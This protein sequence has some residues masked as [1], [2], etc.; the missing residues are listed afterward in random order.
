MNVVEAIRDRNLLGA[1]LSPIATWSA[2]LTVLKAANGV[3]LDEGEAEFFAGVSGGRS[4]PTSP[5]SEFWACVGRRSGKSRIAAAIACHQAALCEHKLSPGEV[6]VVLVL[7]PTKAQANLVLSYC[8]GFLHGSALLASAIE[9]EI[10][11]EI[12][13]K[14]G[15]VIRVSSASF[16]NIRGSTILGCI[17]DECAWWRSDDEVASS[18]PDREIHRAISPALAASGGP[19][20]AISSPYRKVGLL[21]EKHKVYFG[22]DDPGVLVIQADSRAF[23]PTL[24][25]ASI[26]RAY[27]DDGEAASSEWGGLFRSDLANF[28]DDQLIEDAIDRDRPR[29]LPPMKGKRYFAYCDP[30]GGRRDSMTLCVGHREAER[31][32][33]DT[34]RVIKPPFDPSAAVAEFAALAHG[35]GIRRVVGDSYGGEWVSS[36]FRE[37]NLVYERSDMPAS[38][39]F[40]ESLSAFARGVVSIPDDLRLIRELKALERRTHRSGKDSVS[41]PAG[42]HDDAANA[43]CGCLRLA[44]KPANTATM[45]FYV[46]HQAGTLGPHWRDQLGMTPPPP[47]RNVTTTLP[48][49]PKSMRGPL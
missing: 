18:N 28:L 17:Y 8:S 10:V 36:A 24:S 1:A 2:W 3:A 19:L 41:H 7:S 35:Y 34:L 29:E 27:A 48:G 45:G 21:A 13:L 4:P 11:N 9:S 25:E 42:G 33:C 39:L 47:F 40:L 37:A 5:V 30:S 23:N 14:S 15:V 22:A 26:A 43:L 44:V 6:G 12:R 31:F 46:G 38:R 20:I 16:R 32:I 49:L